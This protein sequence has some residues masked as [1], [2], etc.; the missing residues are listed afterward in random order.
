MTDNGSGE[1]RETELRRVQRKARAEGWRAGEIE[2]PRLRSGSPYITVRSSADD[3]G[4]R[5]QS[6]A[7][8]EQ[9]LTQFKD[10]KQRRN[11]ETPS[12]ADSD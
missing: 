8:W 11:D 5:I 2:Y 12:A 1:M 9:T 4:V 6:E 10:E 3:P 7:E